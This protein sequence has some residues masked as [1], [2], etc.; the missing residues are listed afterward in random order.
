MV[1][2]P[3]YYKVAIQSSDPKCQLLENPQ[4]DLLDQYLTYILSIGRIGS[5]NIVSTHG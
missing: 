4:K 2:K 5:A 1:R 3:Q